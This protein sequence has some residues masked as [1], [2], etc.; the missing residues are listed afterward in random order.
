MKKIIERIK[1]LDK[2]TSIRTLALIV[3]I[4]NQVI[5]FISHSSVWYL[6]LS[7]AAL[8]ITAIIEW[9]EN[10][11]VT[12]SAQLAT[13]VLNALQDGKITEDEVKGLIEKK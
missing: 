12:P 6:G 7:L 10:N 5:A 13:K 4:I 9:W 11:D 3:T 1:A 8:I 2:G